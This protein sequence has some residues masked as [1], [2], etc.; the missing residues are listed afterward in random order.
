MFN[1]TT[2][3]E[4]YK[5]RLELSVRAFRDYRPGVYTGRL[6]VFQCKVRPLIHMADPDMGWKQ[7]VDSTVEVRPISG[8]HGNLFSPPQIQILARMIVDLLETPERR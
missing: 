8:H 1:L 3:P 6:A 2:L 5:Q 7:W 4:L